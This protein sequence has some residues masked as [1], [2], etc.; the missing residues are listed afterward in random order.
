MSIEY[1]TSREGLSAVLKDWQTEALRA[2]WKSKDGLN[3]RRVWEQTNVALKPVTI[4]RASIINFLEA[5][6]EM[7]VL[8]GEEKTGKGGHH[9]VYKPAMDEAGFKHFIA[10]KLLERL[11]TNFPEETRKALKNLT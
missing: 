2:V 9:W 7:G 8:N 10:F 11:M 1:D 5:M 4:S 3:S 6:R